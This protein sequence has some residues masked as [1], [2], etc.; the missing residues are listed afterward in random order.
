MKRSFKLAAIVALICGLPFG[1]PAATAEGTEPVG[2]L[3]PYSRPACVTLRK[4][5]IVQQL[6][7]SPHSRF[8]FL[9]GRR[10]CWN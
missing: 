1:P 5:K 7:G 2:E 8:G 10:I 9:Q 4:L 6:Q 3:A